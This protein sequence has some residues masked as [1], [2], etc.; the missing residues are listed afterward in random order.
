MSISR[1]CRVTKFTS[2]RFSLSKYSMILFESCLFLCC[3]EVFDRL[4]S[5]IS[6]EVHIGRFCV[7]IMP[8]PASK[9]A[10][11]SKFRLASPNFHPVQTWWIISGCQSCP[12]TAFSLVLLLLV[13][14]YA[15]KHICRY[16]IL[17]TCVSG[18]Q[19]ILKGL[20]FTSHV[21][22]DNSIIW[23]ILPTIA[24]LIHWTDTSIYILIHS[25][26]TLIYTNSLIISVLALSSL[27][28]GASQ[29]SW[30]L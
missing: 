28:V 18:H 1:E 16:I 8:L 26:R 2:Y 14:S 21:R 12:C 25:S 7:Q 9:V 6:M 24:T 13:D 4:S 3:W 5:I 23:Q 27:L 10:F 30:Q 22:I 15:F 17:Y 19:I 11:P 29:I 20:Q